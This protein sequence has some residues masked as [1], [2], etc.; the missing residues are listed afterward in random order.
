MRRLKD[1][2]QGDLWP[3]KYFRVWENQLVGEEFSKIKSNLAAFTELKISIRHE[4]NKSDINDHTKDDI[5]VNLTIDV[6]NI[7]HW[8]PVAPNT[9]TVGRYVGRIVGKR[10]GGEPFH[11]DEWFEY[12]VTAQTNF[13]R[14]QI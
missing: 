3:F 6:A 8:V 13:G 9:D 5:Y 7:C 2:G 14:E 11:S 1:M 10:A 4:N 12:Y